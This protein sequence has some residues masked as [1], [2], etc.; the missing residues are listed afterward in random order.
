MSMFIFDFLSFDFIDMI[1]LLLIAIFRFNLKKNNGRSYTVEARV[2][3][4]YKLRFYG[5]II[6]LVNPLLGG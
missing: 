5:C 2:S 6:I 1:D 3:I 4:L